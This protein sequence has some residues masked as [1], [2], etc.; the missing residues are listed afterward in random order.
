M[1]IG[2]TVQVHDRK[3]WRRWLSAHHTTAKEVWLVYYKKAS[4]KRRV[5]YNDAVEEALCFGW[6]D[7]LTKA[8]D[9]EKYA[10]RFT[11]RRRG[12]QWSASNIERM[13]KLIA[14]KK[15][16]RAGLAVAG[17]IA[18][19]LRPGSEK[20]SALPRDL[21]QELRSDPLVWKQF[22]RFPASYKRIR[23]GWIEA[24]RRRPEIFRQRLRYFIRM[25]K[26]GK[27]YG[28]IRE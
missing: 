25:T 1:K 10:Q 15:V 14:S 27:R 12:S 11:P 23:I 13:R 7:G 16:T 22:N 28:F 4:G 26:Q 9:D 24:A 5:A 6:I 18:H 17:S 21:E 2:V 8:I 19:K 3:A 20:R